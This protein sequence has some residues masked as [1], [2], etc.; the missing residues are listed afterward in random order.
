M[1]KDVEITGPLADELRRLTSAEKTHESS[2]EPPPFT[3]NFTPEMRELVEMLERANPAFKSKRAEIIRGWEAVIAK[4]SGP[5]QRD[6][7][8]PAHITSDMIARIGA[9]AIKE[10]TG[11]KAGIFAWIEL[12]GGPDGKNPQVVDSEGNYAGGA[13]SPTVLKVLYKLE[14]R[15]IDTAHRHYVEWGANGDPKCDF[16]GCY[17]PTNKRAQFSCSIQVVLYGL[18]A[19]DGQGAS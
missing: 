3:D 7:V 5:R 8:R 4:P 17:H 16:C 15:D 9:W 12:C 1:S 2:A 11:V 18:G 14:R 19:L 13:E 10:S 6:F